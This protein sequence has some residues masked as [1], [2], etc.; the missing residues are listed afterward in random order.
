MASR[1]EHSDLDLSNPSRAEAWL[2]QL[3]ALARS[4]GIKDIDADEDT[5]TDACYGITD[6]FISRAGLDSIETLSLMAA[7]R[8]L[9]SLSFTEIRQLVFQT[10]R[11]RRNLSLR[12]KQLF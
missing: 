10:I 3:A 1:T 7:P 9:E 2:R 8:E 4:K 12:K 11:P 6:L 5:E